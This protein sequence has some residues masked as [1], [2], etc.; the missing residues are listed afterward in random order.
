[1][2]ASVKKTVLSGEYNAP[3]SKSDSHRALIAAALADGFSSASPLAVSKDIE[4]T[5]NALHALDCVVQISGDT[6]L[7][8][9]I[10]GTPHGN[11]RI[12]CGESGSTLRFILPIAAAFGIEAVFT[13]EGKLPQRPMAIYHE[14]L[15]CKG[16]KLDRLEDGELPLKIS[17]KLQAGRFLLG[18]GVSSQFI[19]GLLFALPLLQGDSE[20]IL[21]SRLESKPYVDMT[22]ETLLRFGVKIEE[23]ADGYKISGGQRYI[24][25]AYRIDGDYSNA[26]FFAAAGVLSDGIKIC[27]LNQSSKQGDKEIFKLIKRFGGTITQKDDIITVSRC[28]LHGIEINAEQIPDLV[29]ILAVLGAF[30][31]GETRIYGAHRLKLKESDRLVAITEALSAVGADICCDSDSITIHGGTLLHGGVVSSCNDH[32]IAMSMAVAALYCDGEIIITEAEAINKSYP[33]F[34]ED[35]NKLGGCANVRMG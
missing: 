31:K 34:F 32:R 15:E 10:S 30:A 7:V 28:D 6:A 35:Y 4:A 22:I 33:G 16:I 14:V 21:T 20:I 19:T 27:G 12:F 8:Q 24:P 18:G 5:I 29:P 1:M 2:L 26:A 9:G 3:P 13:G 25:C 23:T 17:G 11:V